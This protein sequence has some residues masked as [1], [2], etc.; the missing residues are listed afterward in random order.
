MKARQIAILAVSVAMVAA[1]IIVVPIPI[2]VTGGFTHPGAI[3]EV[4][5]SLAF[6]AIMGMIAAG[7]GAGTADV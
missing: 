7:L 5:I 3:A 1:L 6:G 4:F 2:P